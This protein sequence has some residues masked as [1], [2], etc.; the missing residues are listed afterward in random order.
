V[1]RVLDAY[2]KPAN[3]VLGVFVPTASPTRATIPPTPDLP[4]RSPT[5]RARETVQAGECFDPTPANIEARLIRRTLA[6]GIK[7]ALLPKKTRG[8]TV[9]AQLRSTGATKAARPTAR[10]PAA[11]PRA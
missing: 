10:A 4:R 11:S 3:R 8:G 9:I 1:Q 5:S 6:N 2:L 7:V